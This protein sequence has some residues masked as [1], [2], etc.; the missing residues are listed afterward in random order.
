ML[1]YSLFSIDLGA[2]VLMINQIIGVIMGVNMATALANE[3][4]VEGK[5]KLT[6]LVYLKLHGYHEQLQQL[7]NN[8]NKLRVRPPDAYLHLAEPKHTLSSTHAKT[9][10][11]RNLPCYS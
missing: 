10:R 6:E 9:I 5:L 3:F 1:R 8:A 4:A 7:C 11:R 2:T